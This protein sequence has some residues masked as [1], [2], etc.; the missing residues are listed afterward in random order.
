MKTAG[1]KNLGAIASESVSDLSFYNLAYWTMYV[2]ELK[3]IYNGILRACRFQESAFDAI[4]V[5]VS[6]VH[7]RLLQPVIQSEVN[8]ALPYSRL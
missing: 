7:R 8:L 6:M 4:N 5:G 1:T 2:V 3:R